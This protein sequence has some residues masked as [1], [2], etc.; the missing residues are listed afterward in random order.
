V[1]ICP[2]CD[3]RLENVRCERCFSLQAPG[4]F[5]CRRCGG[6][7]PREPLL[8][9][10]DAPCPRCTFPLE[11]LSPTGDAPM[12]ECPRCGGLFVS[13]DVLAGVLARA[14]QGGPLPDPPARAAF[15]AVDVTY[16]PCPLCHGAMN[17]MSFGK[18]SGIIVDVCHSHGTWFD[19]GELTRVV[20][21]VSAGGGA[22]VA[23]LFRR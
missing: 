11:L 19:G 2:S 5:A 1:R 15:V 8:D 13:Q 10:T 3:V 20:A 12:H 22:M 16:R 23:P 17:R 7:V 18:R 4:S 9:A 14:E 21:L 6:A